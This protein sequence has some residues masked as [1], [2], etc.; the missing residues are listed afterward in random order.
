MHSPCHTKYSCAWISSWI[1]GDPTHTQARPD[2]PPLHAP[3]KHRKGRGL[4]VG[5]RLCCL[6]IFAFAVVSF[7]IAK[8]SILPKQSNPTVERT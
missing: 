8:E 1:P 2:M 5:R 7:P 4:V 3:L 6:F